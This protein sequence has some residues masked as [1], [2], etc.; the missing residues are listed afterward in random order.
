MP[1]Q[2]SNR[3]RL[4]LRVTP[5]ADEKLRR[6]AQTAGVSVGEVVEALLE[7]HEPES[8]DRTFD[9]VL[10][11]WERIKERAQAD[12]I[13]WEHNRCDRDRYCTCSTCNKLHFWC[14]WATMRTS[15]GRRAKGKENYV[16][17]DAGGNEVP[18]HHHDTWNVPEK[19]KR[20]AKGER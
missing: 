15:E 11:K 10:A 18:E 3:L 20:M 4:G 6:L 12:G 7:G 14:W 19:Y 17:K 1:E 13:E 9:Q 5:T 2:N 16:L 8:R